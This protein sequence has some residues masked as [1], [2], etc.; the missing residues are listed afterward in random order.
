MILS[1]LSKPRSNGAREAPKERGDERP[2]ELE[3]QGPAGD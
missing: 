3:C 1:Q 2:A